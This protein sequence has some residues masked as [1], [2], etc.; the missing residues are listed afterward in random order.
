[1][2]KTR[3]SD[4]ELNSVTF[5]LVFSLRAPAGNW[6]EKARFQTGLF[7]FAE[8]VLRTT[9]WKGAIQA[10]NYDIYIGN[11]RIQYEPAEFLGFDGLIDEVMIYNRALSER[12]ARLLYSN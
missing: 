8:L 6:S 1:M 2:A 9:K 4:R 7:S 11:S 12:E 5:M 3:F 10:N